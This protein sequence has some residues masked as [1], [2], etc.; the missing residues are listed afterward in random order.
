MSRNV[1]WNRITSHHLSSEISG[2]RVDLRYEFAGFLS[3]WKILVDGI[4]QGMERELDDSMIM[5][6][7]LAQLAPVKAGWMSEVEIGA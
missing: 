2:R 5:A 1:R 6:S 7:S 3:G 4:Q